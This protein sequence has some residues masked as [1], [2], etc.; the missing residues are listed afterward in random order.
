MGDIVDLDTEAWSSCVVR[1]LRAKGSNKKSASGQIG[2]DIVVRSLAEIECAPHR[3]YTAV[4]NPVS[5]ILKNFKC[6][7]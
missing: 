6:P 2:Y 7:L 4:H 1:Y 5:L 3:L